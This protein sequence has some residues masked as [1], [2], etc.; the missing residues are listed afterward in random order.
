MNS[1]AAQQLWVPGLERLDEPEFAKIVEETA[2]AAEAAV[3]AANAAAAAAQLD[4]DENDANYS[5]YNNNNNNDDDDVDDDDELVHYESLPSD[6]T[7]EVHE[8]GA[9]RKRSLK[10]RGRLDEP[11]QL[12]AIA[13][14]DERNERNAVAAEQELIKVDG[15]WM[16]LFRR[17]HLIRRKLAMLAT[18]LPRP[19]SS[20]QIGRRQSGSSRASTASSPISSPSS[21][22]QF[23][24]AGGAGDSSVIG[25]L[26]DTIPPTTAPNAHEHKYMLS[27]KDDGTVCEEL[28]RSFEEHLAQADGDLQTFRPAG[29]DLLKMLQLWAIGYYQDF[30]DEQER[31]QTV[32]NPVGAADKQPVSTP[33]VSNYPPAATKVDENAQAA[34]SAAEEA[35]KNDC[36]ESGSDSEDIS[37]EES[38]DD[39]Y[40]DN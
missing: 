13:E 25:S 15:N 29:I 2:A 12:D 21:F 19:Q 4:S 33:A 38:D 35:T 39:E 5:S 16:E 31:R 36:S 20:S 6:S 9:G 26:I 11:R 28:Q 40:R 10:R 32:R 34:V 8:G 37:S 23:A 7:T 17:H 30:I 22:P 1:Q 18:L 27:A 24:P 3:A 14:L